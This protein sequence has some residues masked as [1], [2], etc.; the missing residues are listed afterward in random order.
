MTKKELFMSIS[1]YEELQEK[2]D[3]F[4]GEVLD[5]ECMYHYASLMPPLEYEEG[6][7]DGDVDFLSE[8]VLTFE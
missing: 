7:V 6:I 3:L 5:R 8:P 1:S 2:I 4:R